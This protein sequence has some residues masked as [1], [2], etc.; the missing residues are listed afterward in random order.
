M[1]FW[2]DNSA[3]Y[4]TRSRWHNIVLPD[5][6]LQP[7]LATTPPLSLNTRDN[8]QT[9]SYVFFALE[10]HTKY[11]VRLQ[12]RNRHGW[13]EFSQDFVFSTRS[14]GD[15]PKEL[16]VETLHN[17]NDLSG[18]SESPTVKYNQSEIS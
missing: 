11:E 13:S 17:S 6:N 18:S 10:P 8:R 16:P 2:Q 9:A 7:S 4:D 1:I 5:I 12:A 14:R 15:V 3:V